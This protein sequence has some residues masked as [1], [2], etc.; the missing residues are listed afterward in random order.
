MVSES[1]V[2]HSPLL[3]TLLLMDNDISTVADGALD[4][5]ENLKQL[6]LTGNIQDDKFDW[7]DLIWLFLGNLAISNLLDIKHTSIVFIAF[8]RSHHIVSSLNWW[9][10]REWASKC[11]AYFPAW[12]YFP[13]I[14]QLENIFHIFS[15]SMPRCKKRLHPT[16]E[17]IAVACRLHLREKKVKIMNAFYRQPCIKCFWLA[18]ILDL[19]LMPRRQTVFRVD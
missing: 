2:P 9:P 11:N 7:D 17:R 4:L 1:L 5:V 6:D 12:K 15:S 10:T 19:Y 16:H 18:K 3:S 8:K 13:H 14:F